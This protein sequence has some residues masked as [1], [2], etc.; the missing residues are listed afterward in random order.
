[1]KKYSKILISSLLLASVMLVGQS[2]ERWL[3]QKEFDKIPLEE[4]WQTKEDVDGMVSGAYSQ[5]RDKALPMIFYWGE[6]RGDCIERNTSWNKDDGWVD[7]VVEV[8]EL[9]IS[10]DNRFAKY[11]DVYSVINRCNQI[12]KYAPG[13]LDIDDTFEESDCR[14]IVAEMKWLRCLCYFYLV[15]AFW[16]VPYVTDAYMDD[17]KPFAVAKTSG[18]VIL[19]KLVEELLDIVRP[20]TDTDPGGDL[21]PVNNGESWKKKGRGNVYAAFALLADIYLWQEKYDEAI[22]YCDKIIANV[23]DEEENPD[24]LYSLVQTFTEKDVA[25]NPKDPTNNTWYNQI[26]ANGNSTESIFEVQCNLSDQVNPV[27]SLVYDNDGKGST[28][29]LI[30]NSLGNTTSGKLFGSESGQTRNVRGDVRSVRSDLRIWKYSATSAGN[31]TGRTD[32]QR[33]VNFII[34]RL[35]EI[36]LM[37]AEALIMKEEG[38][39]VNYTEAY[40]I[41]NMIRERGGFDAPHPA[42]FTT[43]QAGLE[44]LLL[45]KQRE[46]IA[47][48]KRWP[49]LV[50][51]ALKKDNL[52]RDMLIDIM[53]ADIAAD[54]R[55]TYRSKLYDSRGYFFPIHQDEID[56][57]YG[58][59]TQNEYYDY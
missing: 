30:P 19:E 51:L 25:G 34:Y 11:V 37:K 2:C 13:V 22:T 6:L 4:F 52:Y 50:R 14:H 53:V 31:T 15:K 42:I 49:D 17:T 38:N 44:Y 26:F 40:D 39:M 24:G 57:S 47:E 56:N 1:M 55:D 46:F 43:E 41:I 36:Y 18:D 32:S 23:I 3:D 10:T 45:E 35:T 5:F 16:D 7:D 21:L 59:V 12:I 29:L 28:R 9:N 8:K 58:V 54:V 20:R 33:G 48:A 27:L